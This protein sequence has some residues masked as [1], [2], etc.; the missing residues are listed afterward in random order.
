VP[1]GSFSKVQSARTLRPQRMPK[2]DDDDDDDDWEA[3]A[4]AAP[5]AWAALLPDRRDPEGHG[6][7]PVC[8][9]SREAFVAVSVS[10]KCQA[11]T[12]D[13]PSIAFSFSALAFVYTLHCG[14]AVIRIS[15]LVPPFFGISHDAVSTRGLQPFVKC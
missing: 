4:D 11:K 2:G 6:P 5:D 14:A 3:L 12:S 8:P 7:K 13:G 15:S 9:P 10:G 1:F